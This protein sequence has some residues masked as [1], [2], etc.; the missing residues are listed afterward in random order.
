ME[1]ETSIDVSNEQSFYA[2]SKS[3]NEILAHVAST[4]NGIT[5][6]EVNN[7]AFNRISYNYHLQKN[8]IVFLC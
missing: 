4:E 7:K 2:Y 6:E 1:N 3:L 5:T 8:F